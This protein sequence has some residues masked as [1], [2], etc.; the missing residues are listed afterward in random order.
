MP[1]LG[2]GAAGHG[3][4]SGSTAPSSA[5]AGVI[6]RAAVAVQIGAAP[7]SR[8]VPPGFVGLSIEYRSAP[9]YFGTPT[10]PDRVFDQ[11]VR[12]LAPGQQPVLRIGGDTT[13]WTWA[14]T[15]GVAKPP[16]IQYT[17]GPQWMSSTAAAAR[18]L[19]ARLILG[20]NFEADNRAIAAAES[21]AL[22]RGVG[23]AHLAGLEL[24]NEP[25]LYG[26]LGWFATPAG[27]PV[28]GRPSTYNFAAYL[29]DYASISRALPRTVPLVGPASGAVPWLS[30]LGRY[31]AANPR[32]RLVTF[33]RY[34]LQRCF[35]PRQSPAFPTIANLLAPS[36]A[37]GPATSVAAA[38]AAAH[39]RGIPFRVDE[40]N[41]VACGGARGVS[42]TFAS[43]L[44]V[45]DTLFNLAHVGVDGVNIHTFHKAFY[46]PFVVSENAGR[47]SAE[48]RPL[49]YGLL[50]FTRAAP[51][52]ARLLPVAD[53]GPSTLR[54][55]STRSPDGQ[56][57]VVLINDSRQEPVTAAIA[58]PAPG[59]DTSTATGI[60][61]RAPH[62]DST[63]DV[64]IGG[65]SFAPGD[66]TGDLS[67]SARTFTLRA[68]SGRFV[69]RLPP[70]TA[71][72]LTIGAGAA[73]SRPARPPT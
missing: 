25:E 3:Q 51:P 35:T 72:L 60:R 59:D 26:A 67:G 31:L 37:S 39:D 62:A 70:A 34:P 64:T 16:G 52:G 13:D 18:A 30:G 69:V 2:V 28:P 46:E 50:M 24:G 4:A 36:A 10:D 20:V 7:D 17:L 43:A 68:V 57:R 32:V 29:R 44:W 54:V 40:L 66:D 48:V 56:V 21:A 22:L 65:Q 5:H 6:P 49:Y 11:L 33:H 38:V 1:L 15:A 55:W 71:T 47:W 9:G 73:L 8:P 42:D 63:T 14:P 58:P 61:L 23:Q 41:S 19:D 27:V 45:L 12:N 53:G